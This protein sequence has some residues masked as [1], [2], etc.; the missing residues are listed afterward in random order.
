MAA[1][2][3]KLDKQWMQYSLDLAQ[4]ALPIDVPVGAVVVKDG[5]I[6]GEGFN[7]RERDNNPLGHAELTAITMAAQQLGQWRLAN[8]ELYVTLEPCTMCASAIFQSRL[9]AVYFGAS[10]PKMGGC[11]GA[12]NLLNSAILVTG[13]ILEDECQQLLKT[14]F[15]EKRQ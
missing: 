1:S 12:V 7:T 15:K 3:P 4:K 14:F 11:G 13:G 10:D 6:I 9:K 5:H 8:C 2:Y